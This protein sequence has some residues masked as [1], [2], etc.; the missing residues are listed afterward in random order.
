[1]T[2]Y[3][4]QEGGTDCGLFAIA[5]ATAIAHGVDHTELKFKQVSMRTHLLKCFKSEKLT[6]FS[7]EK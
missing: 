1:M 6:S 4:K 5:A 7:C 3:Q 2:D